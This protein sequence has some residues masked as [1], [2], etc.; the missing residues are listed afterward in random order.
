MKADKKLIESLYKT[1][2]RKP[3]T[4]DE[5]GL[6]LLA[7]Y[8]V[9]E[10]GVEIDD[11]CIIFSEMDAVSPFRMIRLNNIHGVADL[12][13]LLAIVMHSS[14]IFFNK[15]THEASVHIKPLTLRD[16]LA[17]KLSRFSSK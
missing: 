17:D 8:I 2:R 1:Y 3:E 4:L 12:G 14:I 9:D 5:R 13:G 10:Q 6:Y 16:K 7:D 11:D 15:T